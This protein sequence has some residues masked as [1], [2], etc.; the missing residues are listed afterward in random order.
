MAPL[1][2]LYGNPAT[3]AAALEQA[4]PANARGPAQPN[5]SSVVR[6]KG[7][8]GDVS[9]M[10]GVDEWVDPDN[11]AVP[12]SGVELGDALRIL[13][14]AKTPP[15]GHGGWDIPAGEY[16]PIIN[17]STR[18][19]AYFI[20]DWNASTAG[21]GLSGSFDG[22]H[23]VIRRVAPGSQVGYQ[24]SQF[25]NRNQDRQLPGPWDANLIVGAGSLDS[26]FGPVA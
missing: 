6:H 5:G 21:K 13:N 9:F 22:G 12:H 10:P 26:L 16:G 23:V 4:A 19:L 20:S 14:P 2:T 8:P 25:L 11:Y 24:P 3:T 15:E 18:H 1:A 17:A 7:G